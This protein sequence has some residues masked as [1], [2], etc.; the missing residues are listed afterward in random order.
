MCQKLGNDMAMT[1]QWHGSSSSS[2][3]SS[4]RSSR[5]SSRSMQQQQQ[6]QQQH[7][8]QQHVRKYIHTYVYMLA[9][10]G[11]CWL[12]QSHSKNIAA[13]LQF[14]NNFQHIWAP[15]TKF[16]NIHMPML[17]F[18][19]FSYC[20]SIVKHRVHKLNKTKTCARTGVS[21]IFQKYAAYLNTA[22]KT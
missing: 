4:S 16:E 5:R 13:T 22:S 17:L 11:W 14:Y 19:Q 1:W 21:I 10:A 18:Q 6:Q 12:M 7:Q 8:Q 2:S 9:A 15:R 20:F 3:S